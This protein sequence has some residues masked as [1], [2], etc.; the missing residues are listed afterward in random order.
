MSIAKVMIIG[1][2]GREHAL[3][4]WFG[5]HDHT[6]YA[7]PGNGGTDSFCR[8]I[9]C[10]TDDIEG[11]MRIVNDIS[12]S[13]VVPGPEAPL[14]AGI[15]DRFREAEFYKK[16][17]QILGP[18]KDASVLEGS[19]IAARRFAED[20]GI[21]IPGFAAFDSRDAAKNA[22]AGK[23]F[24]E[25]MSK[26]R[27]VKADGLCAGK[28]VFVCNSHREVCD[29]IDSLPRFGAA[30]EKFLLEEKLVGNEAS[31]TV[32]TDGKS[33]VM[34]PHSQDHKRR[35][36]GDKG[37]NTGG[38]GAYA[39]CA[40]ITPDL[41]ARI[42]RDMIEPTL[43]GILTNGWE[44]NGFLYFAIMVQD[45]KP[46]LIEYNCR[47]GD[48]EA[49]TIIPLID[50][51]TDPYRLMMACIEGRLCNAEFSVKQ[52]F[53]CCVVLTSE[54]YPD[55]GSKG[56]EITIDNDRNPRNDAL[57]FHSGTSMD[58]SRLLTNGGRVLGITGISKE[59]YLD[60]IE[61]AYDAIYDIRFN[62]MSYRRDIGH[63]VIGKR[64]G[65]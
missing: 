54:N 64:E 8:N 23:D 25:I 48:P 32:M 1:S 60:A 58:G 40:L 35:F 18:G 19:K 51:H 20:Y 5:M 43:K 22:S 10:R 53:S 15:V 27:V 9:N 30:G 3:A 52:G 49:Q 12:P 37:P 26:F 36:D 46:Y 4:W 62:G 33:Y 44:Y 29:A 57:I 39:P 50:Q 59:G 24:A 63:R 47:L 42:I 11:I 14:V 16:G 31:V 2:G 55:A 28:G 45:N 65:R 6:L 17:I 41:E 7:V 13:L 61:S 38:M 56:E 34:L 21:P